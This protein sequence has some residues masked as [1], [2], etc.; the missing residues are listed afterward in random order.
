VGVSI[1][2]ASVNRV[3]RALKSFDSTD[4]D[5]SLMRQEDW[6]LVLGFNVAF[7]AMVCSP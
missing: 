7:S 5:G 6:E 2:S 3:L 4:R 1:G